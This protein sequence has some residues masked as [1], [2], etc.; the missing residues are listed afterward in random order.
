[1]IERVP[2][3]IFSLWAGLRESLAG[4]AS[5]EDIATPDRSNRLSEVRISHIHNSS[6][7]TEV[8]LVHGDCI[9]IV[10]DG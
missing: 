10:I 5:Q 6:G 2:I 7:M 1:L 4:K 9:R 8:V 3:V